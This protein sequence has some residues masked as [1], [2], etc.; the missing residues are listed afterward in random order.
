MGD[1]DQEITQIMKKDMDEH[2]ENHCPN[3]DYECPYCGEMGE[4]CYITTSHEEVCEDMMVTCTNTEC[5]E[6]VRRR[7][8]NEHMEYDCDHE[9]IE[10]KRWNI[11]CD[12]KLKR[13][14]MKEHELDDKL[15]LTM[16][17]D[18][19]T[20]MKYQVASL[21]REIDYYESLQYDVESLQEEVATLQDMVANT[22]ADI[23]LPQANPMI[24]RFTNYQAKRKRN[25]ATTSSCFYTSHGYHMAIKLYPNGSPNC[26]GSYITAH[27]NLVA[28]KYDA[29]LKWPFLGTIALTLLNQLDDRNHWT[30]KITLT[31]EHKARVGRSWGLTEFIPH[32][33][34]DHSPVKNTQYLKDDTL[35]F[36]VNVEME[37][38]KPWLGCTAN[39]F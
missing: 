13:K 7:D 28:G 8:I 6:V 24:F 26:K 14:D 9:I 29:K 35:Y 25:S 1:G 20:E 37:D 19:I 15:H 22:K 30:K 16:A 27:V 5:D 38:L 4:Y 23:I 32:S 31:N 10:C 12:I 17:I 2:L 18:T 21:K 11:G 36:K 34:L 39:I 3:R 33:A